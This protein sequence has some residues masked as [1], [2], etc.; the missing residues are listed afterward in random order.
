MDEYMRSE[1]HGM[2]ECYT[3]YAIVEAY[4]ILVILASRYGKLQGISSAVPSF[5]N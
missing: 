3:T 1:L 5:Y 2:L 4:Q